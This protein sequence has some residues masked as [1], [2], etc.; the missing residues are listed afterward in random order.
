MKILNKLVDKSIHDPVMQR[1]I[2]GVVSTT[3]TSEP[4]NLSY[5]CFIGF[6]H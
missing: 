3:I 2:T 1:E 6:V 5:R 4:N